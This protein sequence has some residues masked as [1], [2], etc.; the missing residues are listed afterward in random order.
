MQGAVRVVGGFNACPVVSTPRMAVCYVHY[1]LPSSYIHIMYVQVLGEEFERFK[2]RARNELAKAKVEI[3]E[4]EY[5]I[6]QQVSSEYN[7]QLIE[8]EERHT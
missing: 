5:L 6:R 8:I 3:W 4:K 2:E 7:E 1:V